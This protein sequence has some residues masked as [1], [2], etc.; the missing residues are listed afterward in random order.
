MKKINWMDNISINNIPI[1]LKNKKGIPLEPDALVCWFG[2]FL[3]GNKFDKSSFYVAVTQLETH[4]SIN[5][6]PS[7]QAVN[8]NVEINNN[9]P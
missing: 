8:W 6:G 1:F 3:I 7:I 9:N 4:P 5:L 2:K